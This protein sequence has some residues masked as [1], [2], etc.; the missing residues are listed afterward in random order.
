[1]PTYRDEAH[2]VARGMTAEL[3]GNPKPASWQQQYRSGHQE[4]FLPTAQSDGLD[5]LDRPD[6]LLQDSMTRA[7]IH[8]VLSEPQWLTLVLLYSINDSER[9]AACQR[10]AQ[11]LNTGAGPRFRLWAVGTWALPKMRQQLKEI[12]DWDG[13]ATPKGTLYDW[14]AKIRKQL[15]DWRGSAF[16]HLQVVMAEARLIL[17]KR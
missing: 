14:R 16:S 11:L 2:A 10:L 1:M 8:Q 15:D 12:A 3:A 4:G 17:E 6:R 13:N 7:L 9:I 5:V